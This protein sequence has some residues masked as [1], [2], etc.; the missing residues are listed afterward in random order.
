MQRGNRMRR[1]QKGS[2]HHIRQRKKKWRRCVR[3]NKVMFDTREE[4]ENVIGFRQALHAD[5]DR[6]L[7]Q[8]AYKCPACHKW[9]VTSQ[10]EKRVA[11]KK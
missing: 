1:R 11:N 10:S 9:H 2:Q 3:T 7:P 8:R 6:K 4:G 5:E